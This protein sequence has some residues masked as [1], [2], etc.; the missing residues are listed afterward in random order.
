MKTE[1]WVVGYCAVGNPAGYPTEVLEKI[2]NEGMSTVKMKGLRVVE[3]PGYLTTVDDA[4]SVVR[5]F[6]KEMVDLVIF[7]FASWG[8]GGSV[9][10]VARQLGN[11]PLILWAFGNHTENLTLTGMLEATSNLK[12]TGSDFS[13]IF[14]PPSRAATREEL[15]R[16]MDAICLMKEMHG[17]NFGLIGLNCP[18]MVDSTTDEIS[19]RRKIGCELVH[20]DLSEVFRLCKDIPD[21]EGDAGR[22]EAAIVGGQRRDR[23]KRRRGKCSP[24]LRVEA[25][26]RRASPFRVCNTLLA[27]AQGQPVRVP[28]D[29]VLWH[30]QARGRGNCRGMR[31]GRFR[32]NHHVHA[33]EAVDKARRLPRLQRRQ[34]REKLDCP[35]ALWLECPELGR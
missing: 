29:A 27:R 11:T 7:N 24:L 5:L 26:D 20:L 13:F 15:F 8:E 3:F 9:L 22:R 2:R 16:C 25:N 31:G 19:L 21:P 12:K 10:R 34:F 4:S 33:P 30:G 17:A 32:N 6:K 1:G 23:R 28:H 14:G 18:G 35:L